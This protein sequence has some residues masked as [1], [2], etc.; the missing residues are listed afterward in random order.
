VKTKLSRVSLLC[1]LALLLSAGSA[2]ALS[3]TLAL[4]VTTPEPV[5]VGESFDVEVQ[6]AGLA[7]G[8]L[9]SLRSYNL[10]ISF[11]VGKIDFT[12]VGFSS[13]LTPG[14]TS[15]PTEGA[16]TVQFSQITT[17]SDLTPQPDAFT[18]ATLT[19]TALEVG[20]WGLGFAPLVT[21]SLANQSGATLTPDVT[22]LT[23][24]TVTVPGPGLLG[25]L[26]LGLAA[27]ARRIR[28]L[29]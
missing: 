18:L 21:G 17:T 4:V 20:D 1:G 27:S 15:G 3:I 12:G 8:A 14:F 19:F 13:Q 7:A 6:I 28:R 23:G 16:G 9:P 10:T 5:E 11:P 25:L 29:R 26:A 24:D 22:S 2:Q